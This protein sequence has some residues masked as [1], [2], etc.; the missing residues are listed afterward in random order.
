MMF[1]KDINKNPKDSGQCCVVLGHL[2]AVWC[3]FALPVVAD[4][5]WALLMLVFT[6]Y[7]VWHWFALPSLL[8][9][10]CCNF[11][12]RNR[13]KNWWSSSSFL[14]LPGPQADWQNL[15]VSSGLNCHC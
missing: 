14:L 15:E 6:D 13:P 1:G 2:N 3:W 4:L 5:H 8:I 7:A 9:I 10:V 12:E 11:V